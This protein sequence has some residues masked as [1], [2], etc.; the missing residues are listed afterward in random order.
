MTSPLAMPGVRTPA[1]VVDLD[2]VHANIRAVVARFGGDPRRWRPHVKTAKLGA[3]MRAM[4]DDGLSRF[5]CATTLE[6]KA[7][8]DVGARD[9]LV[10]F[11]HVGANAARIRELAA[12]HPDARVAALIETD[13]HLAAW[14]GTGLPL[15]LD[16]NPGMD[17]TGGTPD[18]A[19][20]IALARAVADAGCAFAGLHWYDGHMHGFDDPAER[21]RAA[22]AG[23]DRLGALVRALADAAIPVAEVIV[24][25][26]PAAVPAATYAGFATWPTDVQVSPGT[27]VYN[28]TTSLVQV[29]ADW[30]LVPAVHVVTTVVS[31]P[32]TTR[33]TCDAGHKSVAADAGVPTCG[34]EEHPDWSPQRP[35]EEH[36]PVDVPPGQPL[37]AIG[38]QLRLVPRHVC[39]TVNNFDDALLVR[40]GRVASVERV[41]A[42]GHEAPL[43]SA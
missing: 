17:R 42:R 39:P 15:F 36:M 8:L 20:L 35:S 14:R 13:A 29:P 31:H 6:L 40:G 11:P 25:G 16:V 9:V 22:H 10:A 28:D 3:V 30:R 26:T 34:I 21:E 41:T 27:V 18:A 38:A 32:R 24:A 4:L 7:L 19:R 33:F 1:L 12:A 5:K 43:G 2:A 37:P 23:Y